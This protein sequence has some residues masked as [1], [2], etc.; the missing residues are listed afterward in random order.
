M[1]QLECH[2]I[3]VPCPTEAVALCELNK[4]R[5]GRQCRRQAPCLTGSLMDRKFAF[6]TLDCKAEHGIGST[7]SPFDIEVRG[8]VQGY[9]KRLPLP[10]A[11]CQ[12]SEMS[13]AESIVKPR[14]AARCRRIRAP[15]VEPS[16]T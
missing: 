4:R 2:P 14:I 3:P 8:R 15:R 9:K 6:E 1:R 7:G 11:V 10:Y 12:N 16:S 13:R 5:S